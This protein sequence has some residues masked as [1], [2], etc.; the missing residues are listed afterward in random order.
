MQLRINVCTF[1]TR[2]WSV[3][4]VSMVYIGY[5]DIWKAY[6][7]YS[8]FA[9]IIPFS[10][11][12]CIIL[13]DISS[14]GLRSRLQRYVYFKLGNRH[15]VVD[16]KVS[17]GKWI[18]WFQHNL[19]HIQNWTRFFFR[20][21]NSFFCCVTLQKGN[22]HECIYMVYSTRKSSFD[23]RKGSRRIVSK[24]ENESIARYNMYHY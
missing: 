17:N 23:R 12:L 20:D 14:H 19:F 2:K 24:H 6:Y 16:M 10:T 15:R 18:M 8:Y 21:D 7:T 11:F 5:F 4:V 1:I 3:F 13:Y 9:V 22:F